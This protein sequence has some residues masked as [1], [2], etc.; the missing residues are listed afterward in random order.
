MLKN[1]DVGLKILQKQITKELPLRSGAKLRLK[2][3]VYFAGSGV[4]KNK[5][6]KWARLKREEKWPHMII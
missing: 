3:H 4:T 1:N 6:Q 2:F 5:K